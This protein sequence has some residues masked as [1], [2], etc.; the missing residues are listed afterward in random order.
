M[1]APALVKVGVPD[2]VAHLLAFYFAVLSE[3]SPPVGLSPSAAAAVTGGNPFKSMMQAWKYS[4]PAFLVPFFFSITP[5]GA[6]LLIIKATLGGFL[7]A[8][9][10]SLSA[11][12]FLSIGIIGYFRG[13]VAVLERLVLITSALLMAVFPIGLSAEGL[14][15]L[16][17]G[18]LLAARNLWAYRKAAISHGR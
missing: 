14:L 10:T 1:V 8:F 4:L 9:A 17:V 15:P 18:L 13:P 3:V 16:A 11:L 2:Y 5:A 12:F 6:N 7:L